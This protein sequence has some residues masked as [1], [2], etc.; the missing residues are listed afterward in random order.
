MREKDL[1]KFLFD[2]FA[3]DKLPSDIQLSYAMQDFNKLHPVHKDYETSVA[4]P[5]TKV[6]SGG[7]N[8]KFKTTI[9]RSK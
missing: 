5:V 1:I 8:G 7:F 2:R 3:A 6:S 4:Y 9:R